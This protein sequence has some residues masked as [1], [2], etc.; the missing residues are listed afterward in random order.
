MTIGYEHLCARG[1]LIASRY[2]V[3]QILGQ[4]ATGY[5]LL[6]HDRELNGK[7]IALKLLYPHL[8]GSGNTFL[9]FQN[10]VLVARELTHPNIARIYEFGSSGANQYY[11]TMEYVPGQTLR[12]KLDSLDGAPLPFDEVTY[13]LNKIA[14]GISYAHHAGVV[15]RDIKPANILLSDDGTVKITDFGIARNLAENQQLTQTGET[16]G[17]PHYMAPE[18]I[19]GTEVDTRSDVYSLGILAYELA[20]GK[21][22][23]EEN[24]Y[25]ALAE[26]HLSRPM[27]DFAT[28]TTGVPIWFQD[29]AHKATEKDPDKRFASANDFLEELER[30]ST[31]RKERKPNFLYWSRSRTRKARRA[32]IIAAIFLAGSI[33]GITVVGSNKKARIWTVGVPAMWLESRFEW[34]LSSLKNLFWIEYSLDN[35]S[36]VKAINNRNTLAVEALLWLGTDRR[37]LDNDGHPLLYLASQFNAVDTV[38]L[39]L[40]HGTDDLN[41]SDADG[42]TPLV[43]AITKVQNPEIAK[44]LV[45]GG[46]DVNHRDVIGRT[47]LF[48]AAHYMPR[49]VHLADA[50]IKAGADVNA[51]HIG[52]RRP[53]GAAIVRGSTDLVKLLVDAGAEINYRQGDGMTPFIDA[54]SY[55]PN[56]KFLK[57]LLDLGADINLSSATGNTPLMIA[58]DTGNSVIVKFLLEN[59][60]AVNLQEEEGR[61]ALFYAAQQGHSSVVAVLLS[62]RADVSLKNIWDQTPLII[63]SGN[64]EV[65]IVDMLI[66]H[67]SDVNA[68]DQRG[69][70][71]LI[72]AVHR[73]QIKNVRLLL[74]AGA[75][76]DI[77]DTKGS[78]ALDHIPPIGGEEIRELLLSDTGKKIE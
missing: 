22:P 49:H 62:H 32:S 63:A 20:T 38:R 18:Q 15:H 74:S 64:A 1:T 36:L 37:T 30:H 56:I 4:G 24:S 14:D 53:I 73:A 66:K 5:V 48:F 44:A 34:D 13:L 10:E 8:V 6:V 17:T 43:Q 33:A 71:P 3:A 51:A 61:T 25:Y 59:D 72:N 12:E 16:V 70:T 52:R 7:K 21:R 41:Y 26:Q 42:F 31:R 55:Q 23:F 68:Q 11:I 65:K 77:A 27:P 57:S 75:K 9:R 50:I 19:R 47:P 35:E 69:V 39:L 78:T 46:A 40:E 29:L 28:K 58:A 45:S 2:E 54:L 76:L 60:A 67:G